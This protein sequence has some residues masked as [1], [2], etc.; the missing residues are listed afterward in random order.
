M[1]SPALP[2]WSSADARL[3]KAMLYRG[4]GADRRPLLGNGFGG[5]KAEGNSPRYGGFGAVSF[6]D[7]RNFGE[8]LEP[9]MCGFKKKL[10]A[11]TGPMTHDAGPWGAA[12]TLKMLHKPNKTLNVRA[13]GSICGG[14]YQCATCAA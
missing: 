10:G 14:K 2:L 6:G 1:E 9:H 12:G 8:V 3:A 4:C 5:A 7:F 13:V 11:Q